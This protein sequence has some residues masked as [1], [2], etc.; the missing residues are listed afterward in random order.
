MRPLSLECRRK[1]SESIKKLWRDGHFDDLRNRLKTGFFK[2]KKHSSDTKFKMRLA[3][4][5]RKR[6]FTPLHR[7]RLS[8]ALKGIRRSF[9]G[10]DPK[11]KKRARVLLNIA[12]AQGKIV[13]LACEVCGDNRSEAH[14]DNYY[15]PLLV[16][17]LC[18]RHHWELEIKKRKNVV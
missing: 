6:V 16:R 17:W 9:D 10:I 15:F 11:I 14:H 18:K 12:I 4:L 3:K 7:K 8:E 1:Q 5:G 13:K 2:G